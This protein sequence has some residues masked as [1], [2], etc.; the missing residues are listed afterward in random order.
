MVS[1]KDQVKADYDG[2]IMNTYGRYPLTIRLGHETY[3]HVYVH[4]FPRMYM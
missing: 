3:I 4:A 2:N 1:S